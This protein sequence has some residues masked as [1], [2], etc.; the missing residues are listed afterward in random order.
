[1]GRIAPFV[2][3]AFDDHFPEA[4]DFCDPTEL[5]RYR[6]ADTDPCGIDHFVL[7]WPSGLIEVTLPLASSSDETGE[8]VIPL[9]EI[10]GRLLPAIRAIWN[11]GHERILGSDAGIPLG[12]D[13][14]I[15]L[16][17]AL[18]GPGSSSPWTAL[19]FPGHAPDP[20]AARPPNPT[21]SAPLVLI[22]LASPPASAAA[23]RAS[24]S[25]SR[26]SVERTCYAEEITTA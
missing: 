10:A 25:V 5:V 23:I 21:R 24:A 8:P 17:R 18:V 11:G 12:L 15:K 16:S 9:V 6:K 26:M 19:A 20:G 4:P 7:V 3:T 13:R 14:E 1:M 2:R 22:R